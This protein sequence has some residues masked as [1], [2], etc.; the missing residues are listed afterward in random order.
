[1]SWTTGKRIFSNLNY[2]QTWYQMAGF[3]LVGIQTRWIRLGVTRYAVGRL[4]SGV[5]ICC[6]DHDKKTLHGQLAVCGIME[7]GL[8]LK[9][10]VGELEAGK[11]TSYL[12]SSV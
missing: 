4:Y 3:I 11:N 9:R 7:V 12:V 5:D 1:M 8:G 6:V 2:S 10:P